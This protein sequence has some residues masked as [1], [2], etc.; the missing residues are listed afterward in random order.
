M[1]CTS[2]QRRLIACERPEEPPPELRDHLAHCASCRD[3]QARLLQLEG[4]LR[5]LSAPPTVM[6]REAFILRFLAGAEAPSVPHL[7]QPRRKEGGRQ[8]VALAFALAAGLAIFALGW[9][10]WP[11]VQDG[12]PTPARPVAHKPD[13]DAQVRDRLAQ[14][15]TPAE[16]VSRLNDLAE[17]V[18]REAR[19]S[20]EDHEKLA[21]AASFYAR[22]VR[23]HLL[24]L[25][26]KVP[27]AERPALLGQ[28]ARQL[29][30]TESEA[31]RLAAHLQS[32][33]APSAA[34]FREIALAA[35]DASRQLRAL[36]RGESA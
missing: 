28:I 12:L 15:R 4:N 20:L 14:A 30:R 26:R 19:G 13:R 24:P 23:E 29:E 25:A 7:A 36:A 1:N 33:A 3:C 31:Q 17:E 34:A 11:R 5:R 18:H 6:A 2:V 35:R 16:Q 9:W 21:E 27:V 10:A 8:K 22:V 32:Q